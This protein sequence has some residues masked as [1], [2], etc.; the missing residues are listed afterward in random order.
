MN[1]D[2]QEMDLGTALRRRQNQAA[3]DKGG[4]SAYFWAQR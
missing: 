1:V 4:W 3:P 2:Y